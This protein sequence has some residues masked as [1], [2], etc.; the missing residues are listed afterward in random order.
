MPEFY[1]TIEGD[2]FDFEDYYLRVAEEMPDNARMVEVGI[3]N[4]KSLIFLAE[5][6]VSL[7]KNFRLIGVDNCAYGGVDQRNY[8]MKNIVKS[9]MAEYVEFWEMDSLAASCKFNDHS[10]HHVFL[11]SSHKYEETK[12]ELRLWYR[13]VMDN[14]SLAGHDVYTIQD[15]ATAV[16]E[17]FDETGAWYTSYTSKGYGVFQVIKNEKLTPR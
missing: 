11:D 17:V 14:Y 9:D 2:L 10:L 13:K 3:A 16:S 7:G 4:G 8:I 1:K 6:M 5:A 12:A 15:V